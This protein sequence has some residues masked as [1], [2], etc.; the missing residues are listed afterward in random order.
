MAQVF[1]ITLD[2]GVPRNHIALWHFHKYLPCSVQVAISDKRIKQDVP[3]DHRPVRHSIEHLPRVAHAA[4]P[5]VGSNQGGGRLDIGDSPRDTGLD[6]ERVDL[7]GLG[8]GG[9]RGYQ[10]RVSV[11]GSAGAVVRAEGAER[12][13]ARGRGGVGGGLGGSGTWRET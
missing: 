2:Y 5:R 10:R 4:E 13:V 1:C 3:G 11:E 7:L 9:E 8:H 12:G 6:E